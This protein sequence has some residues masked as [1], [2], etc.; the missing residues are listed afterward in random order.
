[1]SCRRGANCTL[2]TMLCSFLAGRLQ[3]GLRRVQTEIGMP[4]GPVRLC[5]SM[6]GVWVPSLVRELRFHIKAW[7]KYI[8]KTNKMS[9]WLKTIKKTHTQK[10]LSKSRNRLTLSLRE[11]PWA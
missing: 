6:Q 1:M 11:P 2:S 9:K 8:H 3:L 7:Q 5:A 10:P 4:G